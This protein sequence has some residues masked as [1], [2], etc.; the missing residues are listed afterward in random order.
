MMTLTYQSNDS[1]FAVYLDGRLIAW[2]SHGDDPVHALKAAGEVVGF[3]VE[4]GRLPDLDGGAPQERMP[5]KRDDEYEC[6]LCGFKTTSY[7]KMNFHLKDGHG[8]NEGDSMK[9]FSIHPK[10]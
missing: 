1:C 10:R 9:K 7:Y 3:K 6:R 8:H 5:G 2:G 4:H